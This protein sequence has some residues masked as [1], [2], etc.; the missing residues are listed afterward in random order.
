MAYTIKIHEKELVSNG[1]RVIVLVSDGTQERWLDCVVNSMDEL[2]SY[3]R[4]VI[5]QDEQAKQFY[6]QLKLGTMAL[7]SLNTTPNT[8]TPEE[9]RLSEFNSKVDQLQVKKRHL[10][11]G[12]ID[13]DEYNNFLISV[14]Q[15]Q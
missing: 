2:K 9:K 13:Q 5:N 3:I 1:V 4:N 10:D 6:N 11:L 7:S 15:L 12:I 14:K 8:I